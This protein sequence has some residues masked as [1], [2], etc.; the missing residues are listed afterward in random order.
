MDDISKKLD[1]LIDALGFDIE[2]GAISAGD[3]IDIGKSS[4]VYSS[5]EMR[6]LYPNKHLDCPVFGGNW[7]VSEP[8]SEIKLTKRA[9]K[10]K[11][12][13]SYDCADYKQT[14]FGIDLNLV[15]VEKSA[16]EK[17]IEQLVMA[18]CIEVSINS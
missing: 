2:Q 14:M 4:A 8:V 1:A 7:V 18:H 9:D 3:V 13:K 5:M 10:Y 15:L 11:T 16:A 6:E 12:T 17:L